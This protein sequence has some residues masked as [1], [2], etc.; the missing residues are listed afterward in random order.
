VLIIVSSTARSYGSPSNC[1][2]TA[3]NLRGEKEKITR[4]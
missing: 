2:S 1:R 4:Y 3:T